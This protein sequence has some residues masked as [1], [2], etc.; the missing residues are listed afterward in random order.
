MSALLTAEKPAPQRRARLM[1]RVKHGLE[2]FNAGYR[3]CSP[4]AELSISRYLSEGAALASDVRGRYN[5]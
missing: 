3:T 4:T 1:A 5:Q 2:C